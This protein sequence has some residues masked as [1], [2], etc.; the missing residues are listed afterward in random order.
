[1][2]KPLNATDW[3]NQ[4]YP[5]L[6]GY[7]TRAAMDEY[8]AYYLKEVAWPLAHLLEARQIVF[9]YTDHILYE[10]HHRWRKMAMCDDEL[11]VAVKD[12]LAAYRKAVENG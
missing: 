2:S 8:A 11:C 6:R 9:H 10:Q 7:A 5:D 12:A 1:M 4:T 3:L